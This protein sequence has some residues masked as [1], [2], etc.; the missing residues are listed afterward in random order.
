MVSC[1]NN[2]NGWTNH[3]VSY[4]HLVC[5]KIETNEK[6]VTKKQ[7]SERIKHIDHIALRLTSQL[8]SG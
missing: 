2:M 7:E 5:E 8:S 4:N 3:S 6:S 1:M